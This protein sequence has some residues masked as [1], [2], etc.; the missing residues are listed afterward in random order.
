M[1]LGEERRVRPRGEGGGGGGDRRPFP[2]PQVDVTQAEGDVLRGLRHR[3]VCRR[4]QR[5]SRRFTSCA[6]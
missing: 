3:R 1:L 2:Q 6:S 5:S 4:Q